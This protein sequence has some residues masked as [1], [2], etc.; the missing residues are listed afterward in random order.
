[1]AT[2]RLTWMDFARGICILLVMIMH[3]SAALGAAGIAVPPAISALNA[4][5]A[6]F[7]MPLLMFLSGMLLGRSLDKSARS[8]FVG[9]FAQIYWPFLIWSPVVL[10]AQGLLTPA[11]LMKIPTLSPTYLWYLWFL[12]AYYV[13]AFGLHRWRIPLLPVIGLS[14]VAAALLPDTMRLPR[15]AFLL[16]FFLF[17]HY[18]ARERIAPRGRGGALLAG[19]GL[20]AALVGVGLSLQDVEVRYAPHYAWVPLGM[21]WATLW[22]APA[23]RRPGAAG[24]LVEWIGRNSIVFYVTHLSVQW[25]LSDMLADQGIRQGWVVFSI[26]FAASFALACLLQFGRKGAGGLAAMI[27]TLF[28]ATSLRLLLSQ[29]RMRP[30]RT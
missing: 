5:C 18:I 23:Y 27:G 28:D 2:G 21:I 22:M 8:F 29:G 15:F 10:A 19:L 30:E 6:P 16:P 13:I 4:A 14:L 7:R 24:R 1:M 26:A 25:V 3:T 20:L 11:N 17:G 12:C 9:K